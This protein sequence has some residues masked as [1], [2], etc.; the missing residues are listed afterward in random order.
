MIPEQKKDRNR[1]HPVPAEEMLMANI[2][3]KGF[4]NSY[5]ANVHFSAGAGANLFAGAVC[6]HLAAF[7]LAQRISIMNLL[8]CAAAMIFT[9]AVLNFSV[10]ITCSAF[11]RKVPR[12]VPWVKAAVLGGMILAFVAGVLL[13]PEILTLTTRE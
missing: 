10:Y 7:F 1:S 13:A 2:R 5:L 3:M 9:V 4:M 12:V 8:I 11:S 6:R